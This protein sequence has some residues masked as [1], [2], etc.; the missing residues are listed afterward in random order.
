MSAPPHAGLGPRPARTRTA[1]G[2]RPSSH[3]GHGAPLPYSFGVRGA[4]RTSTAGS[5][6]QLRYCPGAPSARSRHLPPALLVLRGIPYLSKHRADRVK[7]LGD[8]LNMESFDLALLEEV[9]C[10]TRLQGGS[11][12]GGA[13]PG[14]R[15]GKVSL[16]P[17]PR[18]GVNRT[19]S[20]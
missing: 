14:G 20:T 7:R 18:C 5:W 13:L 15:A 10:G 16:T 1:R 2:R 9:G 6:P 4:T 19:S 11:G 12:S 17:S 3:P 8:F